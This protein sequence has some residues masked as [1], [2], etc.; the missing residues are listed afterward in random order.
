MEINFE[1]ILKTFRA[2][3]EEH[4]RNMEECIIALESNPD[5]EEALRTIFRIAHTIKGSSSCLG[6]QGVTEF[7]HELES[8]LELMRKRRIAT[9]PALFSLLLKSVDALREMASIAAIGDD[10][11]NPRHR[12]VMNLL[13]AEA[14]RAQ[15]SAD[16]SVDG[17]ITAGPAG[18]PRTADESHFTS[19][20]AKTLR[21]DIGKLDSLL[22]LTGEIAIARTRI[23]QMLEDQIG[24]EGADILEAYQESDRLHLDLQEMVMKVRMVPLDSIFRQ[25]MRTV[26]DLAKLEGKAARLVIEGGDAEVDTTVVEHLR[27]PLAHMIRNAIDHGIEPPETRLLEGKDL[28][29]CITLRAFREAGQIIIQVADDGAGLQK[30]KIVERARSLG[31]IS[32][33]QELLDREIT[34]LILEPGFSTTET[35]TE[36]SGR[37]VGMDVVRRNIEALGGRITIDSRDGEGTC[38]TICLPLSLAIIEGLAVGV[39]AET[40]VIPLSTVLECMDLAESDEARSKV[41]GIVNLRGKMVPYVRLRKVFDMRSEPPGRENLVVVK[42]DHEMAGLA[43]DDL[44]GESQVVLKPLGALFHGLP[45]LSGSTILG[46]GRVALILDV[47]TLLRSVVKEKGEMALSP[48]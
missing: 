20:Q 40:F 13:I 2:E 29:G 19:D 30:E 4:L 24:R 26:R 6:L 34:Q 46:N 45:G 18:R 36:F 25:Y 28:A 7:S 21:V 16:G 11:L 48:R 41:S 5:D 39:G 37:G 23:R 9:D 3:S 22:N 15:L 27:D 12:G 8:I 42:N 31:L 17:A 10:E 14:N 44:F 43:V 1:S 47:P 38:V 35:V 32:A 33:Q